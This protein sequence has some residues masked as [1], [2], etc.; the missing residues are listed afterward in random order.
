[1]EVTQS[2]LN[3]H[4]A[5]QR[6]RLSQLGVEQAN[7]NYRVTAEKFKAGLTTNS[8]LLDAEVSLLQA[9]LQLTQSR[10]EYELAEARLEKA[11]GSL[12]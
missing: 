9:K 1:L 7:E 10:V 8:E 5:K 6:I 11:I 12:N 3:F 4:Q 2:A